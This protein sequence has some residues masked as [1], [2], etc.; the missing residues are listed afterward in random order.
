MKYIILSVGLASLLLHYSIIT[1]CNNIPDECDN[2]CERMHRHYQCLI[3]NVNKYIPFNG[4]LLTVNMYHSNRC[5]QYNCTYDDCWPKHTYNS[6]NYLM[7]I[8][9]IYFIFYIYKN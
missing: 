2:K 4:N 9:L 1:K 8:F 3:S 7:L 5:N 6:I